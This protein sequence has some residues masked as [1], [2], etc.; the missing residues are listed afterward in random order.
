[1]QAKKCG[2]SYI[3]RLAIGEEII[4][5]L[6]RF[7]RE[8]KVRSGRLHGIGAVKDTT[9]GCFDLA[10]RRY[11]K[12]TFREDHELVT[13]SGNIAWLGREPVLHVHALLA[14]DRLRTCGGH[15]FSG[16]VAVTVEV[17]LV[18]WPIRLERRADPETGLNLLAL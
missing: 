12:R 4:A 8:R 10:R 15:L 16:T 6:A 17:V 11:R 5:T 1:V 14:D 18:P 2:G 3:I 13:M 9:L 7:V